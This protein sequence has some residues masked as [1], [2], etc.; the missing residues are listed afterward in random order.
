MLGTIHAR[1]I[2]GTAARTEV[3][4]GRAWP[5]DLEMETASTATTEEVTMVR[6]EGREIG[7]RAA[8]GQAANYR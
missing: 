4:F 3:A 5:T 8:G 7:R 1:W 6:S 2:D